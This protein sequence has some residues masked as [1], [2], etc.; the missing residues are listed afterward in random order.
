[1]QGVS[2][3]DSGDSRQVFFACSSGMSWPLLV[4]GVVSALIALAQFLDVGLLIALAQPLGLLGAQGDGRKRDG[5][6]V[7]KGGGQA[8][9]RPGEFGIAA[10]RLFDPRRGLLAIE[11]R[12][13]GGGQRQDEKY[14]EKREDAHADKSDLIVIFRQVP[15]L[16]RCASFGAKAR[17]P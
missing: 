16:R 2:A 1:V 13:L 3:S 10:D 7:R 12:S 5:C 9:V 15:D 8:L 4:E 11:A 14:G 6:D 17:I